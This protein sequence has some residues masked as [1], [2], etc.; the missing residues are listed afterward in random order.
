MILLGLDTCGSSGTVA[1]ARVTAGSTLDLLGQAELPGR[2]TAAMLV[3]SVEGLLRDAGLVLSAVTGLVVV[4]GPG[5]FTGIRIGLSTAKALSEA[6]LL[7]LFAI[8]RL[9]VLAVAH[10][11]ACAV[12]DAGR[13]EFFLGCYGEREPSGEPLDA[14][15][16][17]L[18]TE[19]ELASRLAG[20]PDWGKSLVACEP[21]V[22][23]VLPESRIV[24]A[25]LAAEAL[26]AALPAVLAGDAADVAALDGRYLRRSDLYRSPA[27][28]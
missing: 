10:G 17:G 19:S 27:G 15:E 28:L 1:L 4:D 2:S 12:L 16:E 23:T 7:P 8:S 26:Q 25:P 14:G 20:D 9:R 18:L 13:G 11:A 21:T 22:L 24:A 3:P 5:S 6:C